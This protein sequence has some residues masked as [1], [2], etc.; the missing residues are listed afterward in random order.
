M[1]K[2][3][4]YGDMLIYHMFFIPV[5]ISAITFTV[6]GLI[7]QFLKPGLFKSNKK[8]FIKVFIIL[9]IIYLPVKQ[10]ISE[11]LKYADIEKYRDHNYFSSMLKQVL[12]SLI[13]CLTILSSLFQILATKPARGFRIILVITVIILFQFSTSIQDIYQRIGISKTDDKP[14]VIMVFIDTLRDDRT[15]LY[16]HYRPTSVSLDYLGKDS[17]IF[18]NAYA[19]VPKTLQSMAS[20]MTG[21]YPYKTKVRTLNDDLGQE[22]STIAEILRDNGYKTASFIRNAIITEKSGQQQG[23]IFQDSFHTGMEDLM[24]YHLINKKTY[25]ADNAMDMTIKWLSYNQKKRFFIWTHFIEPHWPYYP[26]KKK[27]WYMYNKNISHGFKINKFEVYDKLRVD[28]RAK[29]YVDDA[30][31]LYDAE[32][33]YT[34]DELDRLFNKLK[35]LGLYDNTIIIV[36]SDHGEAFGEH[37]SF[38]DHGRYIYEGEIRVPLVIKLPGNEFANHQVDTPVSLVDL[39]PTVLDI[40]KID[41][42]DSEVD[43]INIIELRGSDKPPRPIYAESCVKEFEK[44]RK[45][46][47]GIKG[48]HRMVLEYPWK[49]ILI[50]KPGGDLI[51]LYNIKDDPEELHDITEDHPEITDRLEKKVREWMSQDIDSNKT[52]VDKQITTIQRD[53]LK[54]LGYVY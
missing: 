13:I 39:F 18:R 41:Y 11:P 26:L 44:I 49:L 7:I 5:I 12:L 50:P 40:L 20:V 21:K 6:I 47:E 4:T 43:G 9:L 19:P 27:Y 29:L 23:F 36:T 42:Y 14:N 22:Q 54:N 31:D 10:Y 35:E 37:G 15:S 46:Y 17:I 2:S 45:Y 30:L 3:L 25:W 1:L 51:E 28:P 52:V 38:F 34:F 48:M 24:V 16:G 53:V 33:T 32:I 8:I